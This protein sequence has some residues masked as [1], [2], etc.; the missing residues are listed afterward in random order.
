[1]VFGAREHL[2]APLPPAARAER[3]LEV[4][5]EK[6]PGFKH[7]KARTGEAAVEDLGSG[8]Q[9]DDLQ[10]RQNCADL[11]DVMDAAKSV[12]L[13]LEHHNEAALRVAVEVVTDPVAR[14]CL[15]WNEPW[16][17]EDD[18]RDEWKHVI[19]E[20][21]PIVIGHATN[22][23]PMMET[24][25]ADPAHLE[26][27]QQRAEQA[28]IALRAAQ[29]QQKMT[30]MRLSE[31]QEK[32]AK[33]R[34]QLRALEENLGQ[35]RAE[36]RRS[37]EACTRVQERL[38]LQEEQVKDA[39]KHRAA[40]TQRL[41]EQEKR[42]KAAED[43]LVASEQK[44]KKSEEARTAVED[45]LKAAEEKIKA[46]Q[47]SASQNRAAPPP[48]SND[49]AL[50]E[51]AGKLQ[52]EKKRNTELEAQLQQAS[53]ANAE[54]QQELDEARRRLKEMPDSS[55][56][57]ESL[58]RELDAE[59]LGSKASLQRVEEL[60]KQ[61]EDALR[62]AQ[63]AEARAKAAEQAAHLH[64]DLP[65]KPPSPDKSVQ[66]GALMRQIEMQTEELDDF[67]RRTQ[68]Q[69]DEVSELRKANAEL[70][71]Q[72]EELRAK[73][74]RKDDRIAKLQ[75]E[76]AAW[77]EERMNMLKSIHALKEKL[78][79]ITEIAEKKGY[80]KIVS[81]IMEEAGLPEMLAGPEFSCFERLYQDALRRQKQFRDR[82]HSRSFVGSP[83][84]GPAVP[85]VQPQ[86]GVGVGVA[87]NR[88]SATADAYSYPADAYRYQRL[89][90][91]F[92]DGGGT[93]GV[94]TS[95]LPPGNAGFQRGHGYYNGQ[96]ADT[97]S[98]TRVTFAQP[99]PSNLGGQT[100]F[101]DALQQGISTRSSSIGRLLLRS[102]SPVKQ[103]SPDASTPMQ[104]LAYLSFS[105]FVPEGLNTRR[106]RSPS[107]SRS[108]SPT[109]GQRRTLTR[110]RTEPGKLP[111]LEASLENIS[112]SSTLK[113]TQ[114]LGAAK[115]RAAT[116]PARDGTL[117][118]TLGRMRGHMLVGRRQGPSY[119]LYEPSKR[120]LYRA[121]RDDSNK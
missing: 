3:P 32:E 81:D 87:A 4:E 95:S 61:L 38:A 47:A 67:R 116:P 39:E 59:R 62:R 54:L 46:L 57:L 115:E 70:E 63:D 72:A 107:A 108:P 28:D 37:E 112:P 71:M 10:W 74:P 8:R 73:I 91:P 69:D 106:S 35:M 26:A 101:R 97:A 18:K 84:Q 58:Q 45:K 66:V 40:A 6:L 109:D 48:S 5:I 65:P 31:L 76:K 93:G 14:K 34:E 90:S 27:L 22:S 55:D 2:R 68:E 117:N 103:L 94:N 77:E 13:A 23:P 79:R 82:M 49:K 56:D 98:G 44:L 64:A 7:L 110:S 15:W 120:L 53:S 80:G 36:L 102:S 52:V 33:A 105:H 51:M 104:S 25:A 17:E 86:L 12:Y 78:R 43:S 99:R 19:K 50:Q 60:S 96:S 111:P 118:Q 24:T 83:T 89:S 11:K 113:L 85:V 114:T 9:I 29:Q 119:E 1:M 100:A 75:E 121:P 16:L 41:A 42:A 30:E 88:P 92:T 20:K 21:L